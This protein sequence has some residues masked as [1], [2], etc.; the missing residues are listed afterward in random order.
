M[1]PSVARLKKKAWALFSKYIRR[2]Y[3]D[4]EGFASCVTCG[5]R[6]KLEELHAGHFVQGRGNA[7]LFDERGVFPQCYVCN[8]RKHGALLEYLDFM[9]R[10]YGEKADEVIADLRSL[11]R[12]TKQFSIQELEDLI[13]ELVGKQQEGVA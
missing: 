7:I 2:K 12:Q 3:A 4:F 9:K 13:V 1:K 6:K 11:G 10:H 8:V 5:V